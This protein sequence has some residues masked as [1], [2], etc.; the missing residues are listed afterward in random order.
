MATNRDRWYDVTLLSIRSSGCLA[1]VV[2]ATETTHVFDPHYDRVIRL[3]L[4][5]VYRHER[6]EGAR[7]NDMLRH[8]WIFDYLTEHVNELDHVFMMDAFDCFF[9][10][11]PFEELNWNDTMAFVD[12]GWLLDNSGPNGGWITECFGASVLSTIGHFDTL[13]SGT[14]YGSARRFLEF[15]KVFL[16][17]DLWEHCAVDQAMLNYLVYSGKLQAA[18]IPYMILP[19]NGTV[20]TLSNCPREFKDVNGMR[21]VFNDKGVVP[22]VVHQWKA[23]DDFRNM[24]VGRCDMTA[25]IRHLENESGQSLNWAP[26]VRDSVYW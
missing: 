23:R 1:R 2:V 19:C 26:P 11:D 3:T 14:I 18:G 10:R 9:H 13:C 17:G 24:Y 25:Y 12:E 5:E 6:V 21:E 4:T 15:E 20:L 8:H 7:S 16:A 22:H